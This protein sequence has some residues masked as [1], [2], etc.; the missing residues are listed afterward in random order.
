MAKNTK[1]DVSTEK[2]LQIVDG[3]LIPEEG[4][5]K[6]INAKFNRLTINKKGQ[7]LIMVHDADEGCYNITYIPIKKTLFCHDYVE[8][9]GVIKYAYFSAEGIGRV[10]KA[11]GD[12]DLNVYVS[13]HLE[14][15]KA[16]PNHVGNFFRTLGM[17]LFFLLIIVGMGFGTYYATHSDV[18]EL[19]RSIMKQTQDQGCD[20]HIGVRDYVYYPNLNNIYTCNDGTRKIYAS[21]LGSIEK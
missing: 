21:T 19:E 20:G 1:V 6:H 15:L 5:H 3:F 7:V 12:I 17:V 18:L 2:A 4:N 11:F 10:K 13:K 8:Y 14:V 9:V 16:K